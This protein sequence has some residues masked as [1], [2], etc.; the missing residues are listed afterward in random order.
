[1]D[2]RSAIK[3]DFRITRPYISLLMRNAN[4]SQWKG[5]LTANGPPGRAKTGHGWRELRR[6]LLQH[7]PRPDGREACE[8]FISLLREAVRNA[9]AALGQQLQ[10]I[11]AV[12]A[13]AQGRVDVRR[14]EAEE[15]ELLVVI[16]HSDYSPYAINDTL[17]RAA[18]GQALTEFGL[19]LITRVYS[20]AEWR[21]IKQAQPLELLPLLGNDVS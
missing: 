9:Q 11:A 4:S 7:N 10:L 19:L 18:F 21:H 12:G 1:M 3:I 15:L 6:R 2:L 13:L 20:V 16:R 14:L 8:R 5:T 17:T